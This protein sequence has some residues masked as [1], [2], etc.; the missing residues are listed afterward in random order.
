METHQDLLA[1]IIPTTYVRQGLQNIHEYHNKLDLLL[2]HQKLPKEGWDDQCIEMCLQ[3]LS[4][5][6]S[7]NFKSNTGV[8]E[9]EGRV[10]SP[11]LQKRHYNFAHGIGRS[12]DIVEV[13]PKA[14]GSSV[15]YILTNKL[16]SE[17]L[18]IA[19]MSKELK[20][21]VV[22]LAT[23]M[24]VAFV[25]KALK[26]LAVKASTENSPRKKY[27]LWSRID[28]KSC[29]KS[30]F[31]EDLIPLVVEPI[32]SSNGEMITNIP[33][34]ERLCIE[35]GDEILCILSTTSCFA[36]RQPDLID[37]IAE[38]C[39]K[40]KVG[41]VINNAYGLQCSLV[42]KAINRAILKGRVDASKWTIFIRIS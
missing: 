25:F 4:L 33:E 8:G 2:R 42:S 36:P 13:Q 16:T 35:K 11:L 12:G 24:S 39:A 5:M 20:C 29:L 17:A 18:H 14:A 28:Q 30:I 41:H 21:I 19:G 26:Q 34:M 22:P 37:K 6:D 9:R 10:F 27:V 38:L 3:E 32:L 31:C 7:N 40:Y 15:I 23:G 1:K